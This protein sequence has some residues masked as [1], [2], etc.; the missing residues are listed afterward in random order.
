MINFYCSQCGT[1]LE[2]PTSLAG[3]ILQCPKCRYPE[4]VPKPAS[5]PEPIKLEG[6]EDTDS[7]SSVAHVHTFASDSKLDRMN[8]KSYTRP[9]QKSGKGATRVR[10][11]HTRL[12]DN[13]MRFLDN[14]INEWIDS[15]PEIEVKF[16]NIAVGVVEAKNREDH[17]IIT[18]WY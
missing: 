11:F 15:D 8:E 2:A 14:M 9:L 3:G 10:T 16:T 4:K 1:A 13:A 18:V 6:T 12:S 7:G 5:E 17:L